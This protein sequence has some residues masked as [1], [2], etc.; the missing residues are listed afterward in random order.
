M[1]QTKLVEKIKTHIF[2]SITFSFFFEN[3]AVY[4]MMWQNI[5]KPGRQPMTIRHMR[6]ARCISKPTNILSEYVMLIAFPL[7]QSLH[8]RSSLL[9]YSTLSALFHL[10]TYSYLHKNKENS[11]GGV[12]STHGG[13]ECTVLVGKPERKTNFYVGVHWVEIVRRILKEFV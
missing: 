7:L 11:V 5:V 12:C 13:N 3:R 6:I 1:F 4:E 9:H 10:S 2:S 8:E